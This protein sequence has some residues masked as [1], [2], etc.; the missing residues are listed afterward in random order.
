MSIPLAI[1]NGFLGN[2]LSQT[3]NSRISSIKNTLHPEEETFIDLGFD[4]CTISQ[5]I[6]TR[7]KKTKKESQSHQNSTR[8]I[9]WGNKLGLQEPP[10]LVSSIE[11]PLVF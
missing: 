6:E 9:N 8:E 10:A 5:A 4:P 2:P 7:A 3:L 1:T 11:T